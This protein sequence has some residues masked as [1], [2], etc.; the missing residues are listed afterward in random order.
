MTV[1]VCPLT[2]SVP[3]LKVLHSAKYGIVRHGNKYADELNLLSWNRENIKLL[4]MLCVMSC[5]KTELLTFRKLGKA[6]S[7]LDVPKM[8]PNWY[9]YWSNISI[10]EPGGMIHVINLH[11]NTVRWLKP[12]FWCSVF[13]LLPLG[14]FSAASIAFRPSPQWLWSKGR[15]CSPVPATTSRLRDGSFGCPRFLTRYTL[16][17]LVS[18]T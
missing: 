1:S 15:H 2:I 14:L 9:D 12:F 11:S 4:S 8:I 13:I 16:R 10:Y 5:V 17:L 3:I 18:D 7:L 6:V